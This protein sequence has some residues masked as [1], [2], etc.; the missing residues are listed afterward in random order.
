M[1]R[2]LRLQNWQKSVRKRQVQQLKN[3]NEGGE[4]AMIMIE[5]CLQSARIRY[6]AFPF[7]FTGNEY[8]VHCRLLHS[9]SARTCSCA[10]AST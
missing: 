2:L 5:L 1:V 6:R 3:E 7:A 4:Q 9:V 8:P 10:S